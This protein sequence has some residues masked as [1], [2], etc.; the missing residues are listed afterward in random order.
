MNGA[1][2]IGAGVLLAFLTGPALAGEFDCIIEP[3]RAGR[4]RC[5]RRARD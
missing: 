5:G 3:S 1:M 4:S 2:R